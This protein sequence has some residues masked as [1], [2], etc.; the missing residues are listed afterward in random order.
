MFLL[1]YFYSA[2]T[3]KDHW[4]IRLHMILLLQFHVST[5]LHYLFIVNKLDKIYKLSANLM[6][7]IKQYAIHA[8]IISKFLKQTN[9]F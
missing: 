9:I 1:K 2:F 3:H 6:L 5:T 8:V 4:F 7:I